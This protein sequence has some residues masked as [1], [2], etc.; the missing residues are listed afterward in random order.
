MGTTSVVLNSL[1][2]ARCELTPD[3][4]EKSA[5]IVR[6]GVEDRLGKM[7]E[8]GEAADH[9]WVGDVGMHSG[10]IGHRRLFV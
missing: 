2:N 5:K 3:T 7:E 8:L 4:P 1:F 9:Y 10:D 6:V